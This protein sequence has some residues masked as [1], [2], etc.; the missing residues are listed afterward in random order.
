MLA[1]PFDIAQS[2]QRSCIDPISLYEKGRVTGNLLKQIHK[3]WKGMPQMVR[4]L[5][6]HT[7]I[8]MGAGWLLLA[9]LLWTDV[10][11]VGSLIWA[12]ETPALAV[13]MLA[14][15]F[16]ITFGGAASAAAVMMLRFEDDQ[17]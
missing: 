4:F 11:G 6:L 9:L 15:A 8:G 17:K 3:G 7:A 10:N 13:G 2:F 5:A 12:S 16:A 14:A 1:R